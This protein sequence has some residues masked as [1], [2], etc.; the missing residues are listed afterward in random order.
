MFRECCLAGNNRAKMQPIM[1]HLPGSKCA[2]L[3]P[4]DCTYR[5]QQPVRRPKLDACEGTTDQILTDD[6]TRGKKQ[7]HTAKGICERLRDEH[8]YTGDYTIVKDYVRHILR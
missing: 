1:M 6:Q 7:R 5:R 2:L 8:S 3:S 4:L